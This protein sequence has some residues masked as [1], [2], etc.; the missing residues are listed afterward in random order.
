MAKK[1]ALTDA[2]RDSHKVTCA[3]HLSTAE[4]LI[5]ECEFGAAKV[6]LEMAWPHA[7]AIGNKDLKSKIFTA[8]NAVRAAIRKASGTASKLPT[9]TPLENASV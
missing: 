7:N 5:R 3:L 4:R 8:L 6:A 1:Q 2:E 9:V